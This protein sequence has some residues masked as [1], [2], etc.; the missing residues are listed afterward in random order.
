MTPT[1]ELET[2]KELLGEFDAVTIYLCNGHGDAI[3]LV[4]NE[5]AMLTTYDYD[6]FRN[7]IE[8]PV[9]SNYKVYYAE[10]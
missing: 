6:V 7:I 4:N 1:R 5:G 9:G 3:G 8:M 10:G 2:E